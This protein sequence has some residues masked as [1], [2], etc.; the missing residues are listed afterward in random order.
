MN[1]NKLLLVEVATNLI[2]YDTMYKGQPEMQK[3]ITNHIITCIEGISN[4]A[5]VSSRRSADLVRQICQSYISALDNPPPKK[6]QVT[7]FD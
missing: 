3:E 7:K 4:S 1:K 2:E 5:W 6:K